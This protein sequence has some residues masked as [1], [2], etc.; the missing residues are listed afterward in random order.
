MS[1][2]INF[3]SAQL[4]PFVIER[5]GR[6]ERSYDI[7]SRLLKDRI[8]FIGFPI[9]DHVANI[10]TAQMLFL[11]MENKKLDIN[12]YL[13]TPGGSITSG[14]A[15]Y[16]TIKYVSCDVSTVCIGQA[17]SMG[18]V[19]LAAG[20]KGKRYALPHARIMLHQPWGGTE[21]TASD[22]SLQAKEILRLKKT[23]NEIL[24]KETNKDIERIEKDADRDFFMSSEEAK[25]YGIVDEVI[26][27]LKED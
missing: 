17:A 27:T 10:V 18:A 9:D 3:P 7:F 19:L 5:D 26:M 25:D 15:I 20:S 21:G 6:G 2:K 23:L 1:N 14:L 12:L 22:I 24:S 13:N 4:T 8:I 16:D 11:A